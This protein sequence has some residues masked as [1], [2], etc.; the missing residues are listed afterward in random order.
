MKLRKNKTVL[1]PQAMRTTHKLLNDENE[2][3]LVYIIFESISTSSIPLIAAEKKTSIRFRE[4]SQLRA[5]LG[6]KTEKSAV[7]TNVLL[8]R[9]QS[10]FGIISNRIMSSCTLD[11]STYSSTSEG[12]EYDT[13]RETVEAEDDPN[14][15]LGTW[16]GQLQQLERAL[17]PPRSFLIRFSVNSDYEQ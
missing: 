17:S 2:K 6:R 12:E 5:H 1:R 11:D 8:L 15:L 16:L 4:L 3:Q 13:D 7:D 10:N 14:K 9:E